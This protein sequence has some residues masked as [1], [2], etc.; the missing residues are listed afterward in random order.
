MDGW[1]KVLDFF[2]RHL[3]H[4]DRFGEGNPV[5]CTWITEKTAVTAYG[6]GVPEWIELTTANVYYDHPVSAPSTTP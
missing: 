4:P 1:Q 6:K 3:A 2:S 5:M